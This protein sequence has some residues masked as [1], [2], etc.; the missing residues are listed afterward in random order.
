MLLLRLS[1]FALALV[2]GDA[3]ATPAGANKWGVGAVPRWV[4]ELAWDARG[5]VR[6]TAPGEST[7]YLLMDEQTRVRAGR[8][9]RYFRRTKRVVTTSGVQDESELTF[10]F[11]PSF[12]RLTLHYIRLVRDGR[13]ID[14]LVPAEVKVVQQE[15]GLDERIYDETLSALVFLRDVRA[16]DVIDFAWSVDGANPVLG[17]HFAADLYVASRHRVGRLRQRLLW[18]S[19]RPLFLKSHGA[20]LKPVTTVSASGTLYTWERRDV[21]AAV[22]EDDTPSWHETVPWIQATDF[23]AWN[24]VALWA[25]GLFADGGASSPELAALAARLKSESLDPLARALAAIRFVQDD[26]RYLG[27]EIGPNTHRPHPPAQV[28]AQ[29]FGD[30]KDKALLLTALLRLVGL[31]ADP[32]LVNTRARQTLDEWHPTAFAFDHVIVRLS[33]G[34]RTVWVDATHAQQG[35]RL[36]EIAVP[37]FRRAL[38]I[39]PD[40]RELASIEIPRLAEPTRV[41]E[42]TWTVGSESTTL[43][44][45]TVYSGDEADEMRSELAH[46]TA[47]DLGRRHLNFRAHDDPG[48]KASTPLS[49]KDDRSANRIVVEEEYALVEFWKRKGRRFFAGTVDGML[50]LPETRLRS[51]PLRVR[52]PVSVRETIVVRLPE[53]I[54]VR[55]ELEH[56]R[57]SAFDY[58]SKT[59]SEGKTLTLEYRYRSLGE[60]VPVTGVKEHVKATKEAREDLSYRLDPPARGF[61]AASRVDARVL[62]LLGSVLGLAAVAW[63]AYAGRRAL[64]RRRLRPEGVF[65]PGEAPATAISARTG[66]E[67]AVKIAARRCR[68]GSRIGDADIR[69]ESIVFNERAMT[70]VSRNCPRCHAEQTL[71]FDGGGQ[72]A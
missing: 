16:G 47:L 32:A 31:E 20:E 34:G 43:G 8:V 18:A 59:G 14:A 64:R 42:E 22:F 63:A 57:S 7:D 55:E 24:D 6:S 67:F 23:A 51:A 21:P 69:R 53:R 50:E 29:R 38:V 35:G 71:Y 2:A 19:D 41:E 17:G 62:Q 48:L 36:F 39:R 65:R 26:V 40:T 61:S 28:L 49:V 60:S 44:V 3:R 54:D 1:A 66:S 9:E 11:D 52:H 12:E 30:C 72:L 70:A 5:G 27:M 37:R 33:A 45:K 10:S 4:E 25:S 68:C 46:T 58:E 56:H 13:S 15:T